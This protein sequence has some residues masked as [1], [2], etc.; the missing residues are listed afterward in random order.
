MH[1]YIYG[2]IFQ[3]IYVNVHI[4]NYVCAYCINMHVLFALCVFV[5]GRVWVGATIYI[6]NMYIYTRACTSRRIAL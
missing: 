1:I 5:L 2:Y 6:C 3:Y 4:L